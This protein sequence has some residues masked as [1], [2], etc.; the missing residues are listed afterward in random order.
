VSKAEEG[1]ASDRAGYV[2]MGPHSGYKPVQTETPDDE[3]TRPT[4]L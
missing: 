4:L 2:M 1:E 3:S